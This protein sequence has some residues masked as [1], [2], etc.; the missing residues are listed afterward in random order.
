[1]K[2]WIKAGLAAVSAA[3][4]ATAAHA[5]DKTYTIALSNGWV[6]S[7]WRTQMIQEAE[8]AAAAWKEKGITVNV[9]V[10]SKNV[11]V[12]GQIA[13]VRNF[14]GQGVN[15]II[16]NPNSPTAFNPTFAQ[17]KAAGIPVFAVDG[18]VTSK[19]AIFVGIDQKEFASLST[20]WLVDTL[21][22]KGEIVSINGVAGHPANQARVEGFRSV[23]EK[24][25]DIKVVNEA[26]AD[27][28]NAK[29]QQV[30]QTLLATYPNLAG[31]WTQ[32][33]QADGVWK[34]LVA[35]GKT[36]IPTTGD[37]RKSFVQQWV[38]GKWNSAVSVNP[39][40]VMGTALNVAVL[41]LEGNE[42][43]DDALQG[44]NGNSLYVPTRLVS[45]ETIQTAVDELKD[46]PDTDVVSFVVSPDELKQR[47]F[48]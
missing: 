11:D 29:S 25:P 7:E 4:L 1:M 14:I 6:G 3:L 10:Q 42:L 18:E 41:M 19:D 12:N 32:D 22:G 38:D 31:I 5:Q 28:D 39:P 13:D 27:W 9:V 37:L 17:A 48:K 45:T 2:T 47:F 44:P 20:Q 33:G 30:T 16:V 23:V 21:G 26:N 8:A 24:Y 46:R 43:K 40:G 15:A 35:A 36:N 34:A